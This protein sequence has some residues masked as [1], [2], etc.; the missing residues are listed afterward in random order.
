MGGAGKFSHENQ[1]IIECWTQ[2]KSS[3][4]P[5]PPSPSTLGD[6]LRMFP[7]EDEKLTT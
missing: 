6:K 7:L 3:A 4:P 5:P 1:A 2:S